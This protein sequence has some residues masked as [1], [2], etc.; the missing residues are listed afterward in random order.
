MSNTQLA[1]MYFRNFLSKRTG[2]FFLVWFFSVVLM[3]IPTLIF[4]IIKGEFVTTGAVL[5]GIFN[6]GIKNLEAGA[7]FAQAIPIPMMKELIIVG[8]INIFSY[9]VINSFIQGA[10]ADYHIN[11]SK[12]KAGLS[13]IKAGFSNLGRMMGINTLI[14]IILLLALGIGFGIGAFV[15]VISSLIIFVFVLSALIYVLIKFAFTPFVA[16]NEKVTWIKAFYSS[17]D[18]TQR[19]TG[20]IAVIV[21]SSALLTQVFSNITGNI[22]FFS[23]ILSSLILVIQLSLLYPLYKKSAGEK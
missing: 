16:A 11:H 1:I 19:M 23:E 5:T 8:I 17:S 6:T 18:K 3:I 10:I 13:F 9:L 21:L 22:V 7:P 15:F 4:V 20:I 2:D 14:A 12:N